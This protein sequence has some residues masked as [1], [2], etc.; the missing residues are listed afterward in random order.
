[1]TLT[2]DIAVDLLDGAV[3][4]DARLVERLTGLIN[5][6]YATAERGLWRDGATR[7]TAPELAELIAAHQIA[8]ATGPLP[9]PGTSRHFRSR[10]GQV[11]WG[12]CSM[13]ALWGPT[14]FGSSS[15]AARLGW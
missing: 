12:A 2:T 14:V 11:R 4:R 13:A 5:G 3:S 6:V 7:T 10:E 1:M 15:G 8:V 9:L